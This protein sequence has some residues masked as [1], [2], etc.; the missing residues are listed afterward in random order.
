MKQTTHTNVYPIAGTNFT[1]FVRDLVTFSRNVF[2]VV[3]APRL[4]GVAILTQAEQGPRLLQL[5]TK[6]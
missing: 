6:I 5:T 2:G 3:W 1:K 4:L